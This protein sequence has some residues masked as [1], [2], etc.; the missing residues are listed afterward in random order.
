MSARAFV[1]QR[2]VDETGVSGTGIVA[3]GVEFS[4]GTVALRWT[5]EWPTSVVFHD[6]GMDSVN[7]VHGHGGKTRVVNIPETTP[8]SFIADG[9]L[10]YANH[11]D[12]DY[13]VWIGSG[14]WCAGCL[15]APTPR[16]TE[17]AHPGWPR[18]DHAPNGLQLVIVHAANAG[19]RFTR[20]PLCPKR[21]AGVVGVDQ[22]EAT[23]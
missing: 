4:D 16:F 17:D 23:E 2:D 15:N 8:W 3:E 1:L 14:W 10:D 11:E 12:H 9:N 7:H 19:G 6:R 5:S 22:P 21:A 20:R 18:L 13:G